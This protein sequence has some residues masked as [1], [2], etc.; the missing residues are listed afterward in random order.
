MAVKNVGSEELTP[1]ISN[2]LYVNRANFGE[3]EHTSSK[4]TGYLVQYKVEE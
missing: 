4:R 3:T 2:C 1:R